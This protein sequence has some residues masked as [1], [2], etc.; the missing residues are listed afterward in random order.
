MSLRSEDK[1]SRGG[2]WDICLLKLACGHLSVVLA[3]LDICLALSARV[4][5]CL[6]VSGREGG[7]GI[8]PVKYEVEDRCDGVTA[9]R[10]GCRAC[11]HSVS[12]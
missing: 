1:V 9:V 3:G 5:S 4:D 7:C 10:Q 6:E 11:R 8:F 2:A 12:H